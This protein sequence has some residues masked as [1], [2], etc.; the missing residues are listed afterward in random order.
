MEA[1]RGAR[2]IFN[3]RL[4]VAV[5][6]L[7]MTV[8]VLV[9]ISSVRVWLGILQGRTPATTREAPYVATTYAT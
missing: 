5:A 9:V 2:L 4:N 8:V 7:F 6:A 3:D 1:S